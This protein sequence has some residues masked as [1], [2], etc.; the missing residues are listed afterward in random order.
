MMKRHAGHHAA[1]LLLVGAMSA[2]LAAC[3]GSSGDDDPL[4]GDFEVF[5]PDDVD[6][7]GIPN[8]EDVDYDPSDLDGDGIL[9]LEDDD[10]D[11]DG[12]LNEDDED[13][14]ENDADG[15]G[16]PDTS[17][18]DVCGG[19]PGTDA[20]SSNFTWDDN[21]LVR[22][23]G[24]APGEGQFADSL[25]AAGIQRVVYCAGFGEA[26]SVDAFTDGEYG[27][28]SEQAVTAFQT[29]YN[30]ANPDDVIGVDGRVGAQTW[31][32]LQ[33]EL[34]L[35]Q[36][37]VFEGDGPFYDGYG[38]QG[39]RCGDTVL[40]L[41]EVESVDGG[42]GGIDRLGW[43]LTTGANDPTP[44]PFSTAQPFGVID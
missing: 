31:A 36:P 7:D 14:V 10:V 2:A 44:V 8:A 41:N 23:E 40:F 35:V 1:R 28:G 24:Q 20:T 5:D 11:G 29:A 15:D 42:T 17:A 32:A 19:E 37:A 43:Q 3:G 13:F 34:D 6:G 12:I 26:A 38:V 27:P 18:E 16:F 25:Y 4:D 9:N 39:D 21:C 30:A 33:A 22:R